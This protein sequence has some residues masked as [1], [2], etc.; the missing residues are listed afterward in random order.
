MKVSTLR[1]EPRLD[2]GNNRGLHIQT[3]GEHNDQPQRYAE[4]V[5]ASATGSSCVE[6]YR[7]FI[8]GRGFAQTDFAAAAVDSRGTTADALLRAVADDYA[9]FG[10]F[11]LHVNYNA[12]YEVVS[13]SH[14]PLEFVRFEELDEALHFTRVALH[15]D[16][17]RRFM[18]LRPF[19]PRDIEWFGLFD[20]DPAT[21]DREVS[22]AG[23]WNGYRGQIFYYSNRGERVYPLPIYEAAVTDMSTEEGFSNI[24][25][26][27]ARNNFLPAGMIVDFDQTSSSGEQEEQTREEL[28]AF[29]Q[30]TNA[31]N[32]MYTTLRNGDQEP[33]FIPFKGNNYD[34]EFRNGEERVPQIIGRCF[35]QPPILRAEDVGS[36][37]G[38]D[39]MTNAYDFYN[40]ITE[41]ERT[42]VARV[43]GRIFRLWHDPSINPEDDYSI[44]AKVYRVNTSLAERL[45]G[46]AAEVLALVF[47][48]SKEIEVKRRVLKTIYGL[49]QEEIDDLLGMS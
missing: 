34:S 47:D 7:K 45:G 10:G 40:A 46:S 25:L 1:T 37:F 43:F 28:R 23:G 13:V 48:P 49:D 14:V 42:A 12:L 27:N 19:R 41:D 20:P 36:H 30:D 22:A 3:Y 35:V 39:L 2:T 26:R 4:I 17:G 32:L 16:W 15:P 9:R 21:I 5:A 18:R 31:G 11:A 29:Q 8:E 6:T 24:R 33:R 44:L 38:A